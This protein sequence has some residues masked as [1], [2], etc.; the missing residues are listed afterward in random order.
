M[1]LLAQL[2]MGNQRIVN[3]GDP[4][5]A[6][7]VVNLQTLQNYIAGLAWKDEVRAASTANINTAS[8]GATL[9]GVTLVS[10]DRILLKDQSTASQN[11]IYV[12]TGAAAALTRSFDADSTTD[13]RSA[14][15]TVAEGTVNADKVFT[16]TA[17]VA[18][19]GT[20]AQ[21]WVAGPSGGTTYTQG[22]GISISGGTISA[23]ADPAAGAG[24]QV[25][26]S[27]I[28]LDTAVAVRK[29]AAD[30]G[31]GSATSIAVVHNLG[32]ADVTWSLRQKSDNAHVLT[33]A[34]S[35]DANTLTLTFATAP[36]ASALRVVVHG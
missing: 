1:K 10:G 26:S 27:G 13:L 23:V 5:A 32:T 28:K 29:Y 35:T 20:T 25:T 17:E 21:T 4:S 19:V 12:W 8:P 34:V 3:V 31:N 18:T 33:D 24:V 14:T 7:D 6:T 16:Q 11:G 36:A 2:D 15:V 30:I 9:D 22:N